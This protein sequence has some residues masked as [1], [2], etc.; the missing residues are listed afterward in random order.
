MTHQL[1][2][3]ETCRN[4]RNCVVILELYIHTYIVRLKLSNIFSAQYD[5][6]IF[7]TTTVRTSSPT[8][9]LSRICVCDCRRGMDWIIGFIDH[10]YTR[11]GTASNYNAIAHLHTS[12]ITTAPAKSPPASHVLT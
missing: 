10:L 2:M 11:L 9:V 6:K 4:C 1:E 5:A 7:I 8:N 3:A 12:Q